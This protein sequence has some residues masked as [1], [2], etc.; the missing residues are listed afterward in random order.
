M[1]RAVEAM[2]PASSFAVAAMATIVAVAAAATPC[3]VLAQ[4]IVNIG[5]S[6]PLSGP[7]AAAGKDNQVGAVMA[8]DE[9]NQKKPVIGGKPVVFHLIAEDDQANPR[10]G[11]AAAARLIEAKVKAL[12]GPYNSDVAIDTARLFNDAG[13]VMAT[14][15]SHPRIT[16]Q[17]F[18]YVF[19][20]S[21]NDNQ[22]GGEMAIYAARQLSLKKVLVIED[23]TAYGKGIADA[24]VAAARGNRIDIAG[25]KSGSQ[26]NA[27]LMQ[28][29]GRHVDGIFYGGYYAQAAALKIQ[30]KK[31]GIDAALMGGDA[32]C[33]TEMGRL[34]GPA[35][36]DSVYCIRG[37]VRLGVR[38]AEKTFLAEYRKRYGKM[39]STFGPYFYDG[40]KMIAAAMQ[41][42]DSTDPARYAS[43]L[44]GMRYAGVVGDYEF[45]G[46]H[47]MKNSPVTIYQFKNGELAVAPGN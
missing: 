15:G 35:V 31:I 44:A 45:D 24:F 13:I 3:V 17:G 18:R 1:R 14:V 19:R 2:I 4:D 21:P 34:A 36:N 40:V 27:I 30:M 37:G 42:A 7:Q 46:A 20:L 33:N 9:L 6:S 16:Q 8:I 43:V 38:P 28:F 22:L 12:V 47:D 23:G 25:R 32:V 10:I 39:P 11:A 41:K 5:F 26:L 29:K